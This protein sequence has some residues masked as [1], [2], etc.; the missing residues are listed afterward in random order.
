MPIS[1]AES[2]WALEGFWVEGG[3][4]FS[5][6]NETVELALL[7]KQWVKINEF[8]TKIVFFK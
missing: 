1:M 5:P 8:C 4:A 7:I 2:V 6:F 3:E